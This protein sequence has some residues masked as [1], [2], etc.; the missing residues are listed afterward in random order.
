MFSIPFQLFHL[1]YKND[2]IIED[3]KTVEK[4]AHIP[5]IQNLI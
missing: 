2:I 1:F 5:D 4:F 3:I